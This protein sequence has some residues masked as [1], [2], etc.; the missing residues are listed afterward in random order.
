VTAF[1]AGS[2]TITARFTSDTTRTASATVIVT[3]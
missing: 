3:P 1:T 2:A